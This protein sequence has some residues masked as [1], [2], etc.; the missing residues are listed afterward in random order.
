MIITKDAQEI[1]WMKEAGRV[2]A[3][4]HQKLAMVIV[5]GI[6]TKQ[7]NEICEEVIYANGATPSFLNLYGFPASVCTSINE[8]VVHGIPDN[9][10]LKNGDIISV[11]VGACVHGYHGDSAWTYAVG[12]ID[13]KAKQLMDVCEQSLYVGLEQVKPG[14]R[15]SDISYAIQTYLESNGCQTPRD[16]TGHGIGSTVHEDPAVPNFGNPGRGP[17]L[18]KGMALAI[19]PMA[20]LGAKE[21]QTLQDGWTVVTR[22]RSLAAH[23]EHTVIITD[24]GYEI[25]TKL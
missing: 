24:D 23:F 7:I 9:T 18:K 3:L 21:T 16:Y 20:H 8:V 1:V 5:P 4:V 2:V 25:T 17:R 22:D 6:T 19:E 13:E 10:V 12:T 15:V 14:N 11:D